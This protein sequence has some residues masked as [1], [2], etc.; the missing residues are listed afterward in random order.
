MISDIFCAGGDTTFGFICDIA[1]MWG[2][3][4]PL[5]AIAA[6]LVKAPILVVF[7]ILN[8]DEMIKLPMV[9]KHYIKYKWVKNLAITGKGGQ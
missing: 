3:I 4:I 2:I 8:L 9:Y 5:A 7:F 1:V 6:F